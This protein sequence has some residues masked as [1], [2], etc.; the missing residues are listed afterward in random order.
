LKCET[1]DSCRPVARLNGQD[2]FA[3]TGYRDEIGP[4]DTMFVWE[5]GRD[6]GIRAGF[7][8]EGVPQVMREMGSE[9]PYWAERDT[10]VQC[11]VL[12]TIV[13]RDVNLSHTYLRSVPGLENL[14]VFHG[15]QQGTNFPVPPQE[16]AILLQLVGELH[17]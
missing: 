5:T 11:R 13:D 9:Q 14:S 7:R 8:A 1:D 15:F 16:G 4:G 10:E 2:G 17:A 6:R 3:L 12:A